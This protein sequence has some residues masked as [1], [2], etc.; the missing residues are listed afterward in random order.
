RTNERGR[1]DFWKKLITTLAPLVKLYFKAMS[2]IYAEKIVPTIIDMCYKKCLCEESVM[3]C[4]KGEILS[5][6]SEDM[7][8]LLLYSLELKEPLEE[9]TLYTNALL[10]LP[11]PSQYECVENLYTSLDELKSNLLKFIEGFE[12]KEMLSERDKVKINEIKNSIQQNQFVE[13]FDKVNTHFPRLLFEVINSGHFWDITYLIRRWESEIITG[14]VDKD[15][16]KKKCYLQVLYKFGEKEL[17]S[18]FL[19]G[20]K[21]RFMQYIMMKNIDAYLTLLI[22][23][24]DYL[25]STLLYLDISFKNILAYLYILPY[26]LY[27]LLSTYKVEKC[28]YGKQ[29]DA[30][31]ATGYEKLEDIRKRIEKYKCI[32]TDSKMAIGCYIEQDGLFAGVKEEIKSILDKE[33]ISLNNLTFRLKDIGNN[34]FGYYKSISKVNEFINSCV[35]R[36]AITRLGE[37]L[38]NP[39]LTPTLLAACTLSDTFRCGN[40]RCLDVF[41]DSNICKDPVADCSTVFQ[42]APAICYSCKDDTCYALCKNCNREANSAFSYMRIE[43]IIPYLLKPSSGV[44]KEE[45]CSY[46]RDLYTKSCEFLE[47]KKEGEKITWADVNNGVRLGRLCNSVYNKV[48]VEEI[49]VYMEGIKGRWGNAYIEL[50]KNFITTEKLKELFTKYEQNSLCDN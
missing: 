47:L 8:G 33:E 50:L 25:P 28:Y 6:A 45:I 43:T 2:R 49:E 46:I 24:L 35:Y 13:A 40:K 15:I 11:P 17:F 39:T 26:K 31:T 4:K 14:V 16:D 44:K 1:M 18:N 20:K 9:L 37:I 3:K 32:F 42:S 34:S 12:K 48:N 23:D 36:E 30:R 7:A 38:N 5:L 27:S 22:R 19:G 29:D 41:V 21:L 10:T